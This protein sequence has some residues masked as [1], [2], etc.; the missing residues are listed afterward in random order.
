MGATPSQLQVTS[1]TVV[2]I[3]GNMAATAA[4]KAPMVNIM[5]FGVCKMKPSITGYLPCVPAPVMWTGYV[6]SV[7]IPGGNPLVDTSKIQCS[8]GGMISFQNSGQMKPN[9]VETKPTSPQ[10]EAL[11]R[12][13]AGDSPAAFCE[14]CE[15]REKPQGA[16]EEKKKKKKKGRDEK[17]EE[18]KPRIT[19][20]YWMDETENIPKCLSELDENAEVTLFLE[21]EDAKQGETVSVTLFPPDD[22]LFEGNQKELKITGTVEEDEK[23]QIV[24]IEKFCFRFESSK[25]NHQKQL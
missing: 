24:I 19:D 22:E 8:C 17:E 4:D 7:Q 14:I 5:P 18:K 2:S 12:A 13:A 1:N 9:K 23:G 11:K 20:I 16:Q 10:I 3:Q 6:A 15:E 25:N 21:V